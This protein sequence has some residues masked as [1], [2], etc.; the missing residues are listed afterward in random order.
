MRRSV[1]VEHQRLVAELRDNGVAVHDDLPAAGL[2]LGD[3]CTDDADELTADLHRDCPGH[4]TY[5]P[6]SLDDAVYLCA[7]P[8]EYGHSFLDATDAARLRLRA[9]L[10]ADGITVFEGSPGVG[11][12][13]ITML[14]HDGQRLAG[15]NH[16]DCPGHAAS[17]STWRAVVDYYCTNPTEYGHEPYAFTPAAPA[18][19]PKPEGPPVKLVRDGNVAWR[20]AAVQRRRWLLGV[21]FNRKKGAPKGAAAFVLRMLA[22]SPTPLKDGIHAAANG[23][24]FTELTGKSRA[25][26]AEE[27]ATMSASRMALMQVALIAAEFERQMATT[28]PKSGS[29]D[30]N[31]TWRTDRANPYCTREEAAAYLKFLAEAGRKLS[32][33]EKAV[34]KGVS[35]TGVDPDAEEPAGE[36]GGD[37]DG[38]ASDAAGPSPDQAREPVAEVDMGSP[39]DVAEDSSGPGRLAGADGSSSAD[40]GERDSSEES[41]ADEPGREL[42]DAA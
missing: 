37:A 2:P 4:G 23:D 9:G 16:R 24:L 21:L 14:Q 7:D 42:A 13:Q 35:Y 31:Y 5:F 19:K 15:D 27:V 39:A 1:H 34:A 30:R 29:G 33:I 18:A 3:L 38:Q 11:A 36:V 28:D 32:W 6:D 8:V 25:K 26:V 41:P 12:R 22:T 17:I 40:A 20:A 10:I